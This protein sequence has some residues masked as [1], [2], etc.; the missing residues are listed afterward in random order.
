MMWTDRSNLG[1]DAAKRKQ[2]RA[3]KALWQIQDAKSC[4]MI[5][6]YEDNQYA[7]KHG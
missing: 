3:K 5:E 7:R 2:S 6:R 4:S 1:A